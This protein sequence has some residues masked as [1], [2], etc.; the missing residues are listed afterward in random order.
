MFIML[1]KTLNLFI[2]QSGFQELKRRA[3]TIG[4][5]GL[6][7]M[8]GF[9]AANLLSKGTKVAVYDIAKEAVEPVIRKGATDCSSPADVA[10][11]S[12][13]LFTMLPNNDIVADTYNGKNGVFSGA[14]KGA[15]FVD[16]STISPLVAQNVGS[17]AQEKGFNFIDAPVS[18]GVVGARDATLTFMVG[19]TKEN[20]QR[21]EPYILQMGQRAVHCGSLGA[22][23]IAKISNNMLLAITMIGVS[24]AM[25]LGIKLGL[26]PKTLMD[27]INTSTGRCW[28]SEVYNPVPNLM[29]NVPSS[30]NYAGGFAVKLVTKDLGIAQDIA[31]KSGTPI[32][33]GALAHQVYMTMSNKGL[34]DKDFAVIYEYL[35]KK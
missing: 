34:G 16:S 5:I 18:G 7:N 31:T 12:D 26:D 32:P 4:F 17:S 22:G 15:L 29:E 21:A 23:Q 14:K 24:E 1:V 13:V 30:N 25:N 9:M 27:I 11:Q 28:S 8:G 33:M 10:A 2:M 20:M 6:G 19:G 3:S 35:Q